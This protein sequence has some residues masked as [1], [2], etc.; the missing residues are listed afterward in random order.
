MPITVTA[1]DVTPLR[2][3]VP[4]RFRR[5]TSPRDTDALLTEISTLVA[6][7]Q[8]LR[9]KGASSLRLERNRIRIARAQWELS[10]S[11]IRRYRPE[12]AA[13]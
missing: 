5:A 1:M 4:A 6:E 9:A 2:P 10:Y 7:R 12:S 8:Q 3:A 11:L 13:A